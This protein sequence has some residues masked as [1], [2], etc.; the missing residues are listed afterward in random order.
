MIPKKIG[1]YIAQLRKEHNWT[2]E[3]LADR[4]SVSDKTIS[5]WE[6][7]NGLPDITIIPML[8]KTLGVT[9]DEILSGE[10]KK[11]ATNESIYAKIA[12]G[13]LNLIEQIENG[14][15][16][17]KLDEYGKSLADYCALKNNI[18]VFRMLL[19]LNKV[20][21]A[22]KT[23]VRD[24]MN[25]QPTGKET[26]TYEDVMI[27][28]RA[29]CAEGYVNSYPK[30]YSDSSLVCLAL[31]NRADEILL[32]V[33]LENRAFNAAEAQCIADDFDYYYKNYFTREFPS[34]VGAIVLAL[35]KNGK[36]KEAQKMLDLIVTYRE[37][38]EKK[39]ADCEKET[40][41]LGY[42]WI[43]QWNTGVINEP[44]YNKNL[45]KRVIMRDKIMAYVWGVNIRPRIIGNAIIFTQDE[46]VEIGFTDSEFLLL[47]KK[48]EIAPIIDAAVMMRLLENDDIK[49]FEAFT[50]GE[51]LNADLQ[52][53]IL[54]SNGKIK[55]HYTKSNEIKDFNEVLAA[56]D[57]SLALSLLAKPKDIVLKIKD[58]K[59]ALLGSKEMTPIL[60]KFIPFLGQDILDNLL[61]DVVPQ[62][63]TEARIALL[64]GGAKVL[65]WQNDSYGYGGQWVHDNT[66]TEILYK[67]LK[68]E[69]K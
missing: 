49:V 54:N 27:Y 7:G 28:D 56:G 40:Q 38:I 53:L 22:N 3:E 11:S 20:H 15:N 62:D 19:K 64:E 51:D 12:S 47:C 50:D 10:S 60:K 61:K 36:R 8:A 41:S 35:V 52:K 16:I 25:M 69:A 42:H 46:L 6:N 2:Q 65:V 66:Q 5:K 59:I 34:H 58:L 23:E 29:Y 1:K 45:N 39:R 37:Q 18:D 9:A 30:A 24:N 44:V 31:K 32:Q 63:N 68:S 48:I 14:L 57:V 67:L 4:L 26:I 13:D 55:A 43:I 21:I 33:N 17:D